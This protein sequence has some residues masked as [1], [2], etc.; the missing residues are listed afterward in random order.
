MSTKGMTT[1]GMNGRRIG[2]GVA[3]LTAVAYGN[4]AWGVRPVSAQPQAQPTVVSFR[5]MPPSDPKPDD[6]KKPHRHGNA[7]LSPASDL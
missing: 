6:P 4:V 5:T 7:E 2:F 3:V 1:T